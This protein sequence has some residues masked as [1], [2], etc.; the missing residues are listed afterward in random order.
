MQHLMS[1]DILA[2]TDKQKID[3]CLGQRKKNQKLID[4]LLKIGGNALQEFMT[5]LTLNKAYEKLEAKI[6]GSKG[7]IYTV[8]KYLSY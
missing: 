8:L 5:A 3:E 2:A 7:E 1:K 6:K 4:T